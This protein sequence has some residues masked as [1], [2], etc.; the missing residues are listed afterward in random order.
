M[1]CA[2]LVSGDAFFTGVALPSA[3]LTVQR[4]SGACLVVVCVCAWWGIARCTLSWGLVFVL[5]EEGQLEPTHGQ[6]V[7]HDCV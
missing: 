6:T 4:G 7:F 2:C 3:G 5:V 1:V